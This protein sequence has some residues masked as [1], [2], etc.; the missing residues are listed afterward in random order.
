MN[1]LGPGDHLGA[2]AL[3]IDNPKEARRNATAF[4]LEDTD[5]VVMMKKDFK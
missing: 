5:V 4:C 3:E 1:V 2:K